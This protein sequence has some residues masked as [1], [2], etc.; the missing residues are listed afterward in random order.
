MVFGLKDAKSG[1]FH[2]ISLNLAKFSVLPLKVP[3]IPLNST[4]NYYCFVHRA[5][6][7]D[8]I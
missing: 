5:G 3:K 2:D 8:G 7:G 1:D 4:G 6:G